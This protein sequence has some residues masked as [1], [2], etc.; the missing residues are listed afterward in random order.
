M[1]FADDPHQVRLAAFGFRPGERFN[2][3][4]NFHLPWRHEIRVEPIG[5]PAPNQRYPSVVAT[6]VPRHCRSATVRRPFSPCASTTPR[7]T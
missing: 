1:T 3:E 7:S 6:L 2:Y 4:Y 5:S